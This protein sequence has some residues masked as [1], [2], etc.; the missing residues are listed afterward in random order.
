MVR[1]IFSVTRLASLIIRYLALTLEGILPV[2]ITA[3]QKYAHIHGRP[4]AAFSLSSGT[5]GAAL[6][7]S[8]SKV[9]SIAISYGT[10]LH[11]T[12]PTLFEPA[13][14]LG[15]HIIQDLWD[16]WGI[17][18]GGLRNG[19]IDLYSINI[20]MIQEL[21][22]DDGLKICWTTIW[23][24]SY[25][26]LFK[27][28]ASPSKSKQMVTTGPAAELDALSDDGHSTPTENGDQVQ[29][30]RL[31]F[32]FAPDMA[33]LINP[34]VS[35]LPV[36]SDGWAIQQGWVSVTPLRASYGEP[37]RQQTGEVIDQVWKMKL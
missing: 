2:C 33:G 5:I 13:H 22:S 14:T 7:S 9:R 10:V 36:G 24:N 35:T 12:P 19:E 30:Q 32:K 1:A 29:P 21:L 4:T 8:L 28:V 15:S 27:Q 23:R 17:D 37:S 16:N 6:S 34:V 11:P 18:E 26:R 20:P 3:R 31:A 25:G